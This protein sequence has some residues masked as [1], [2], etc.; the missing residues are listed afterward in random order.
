ML[1]YNYWK[2]IDIIVKYANVNYKYYA[3]TR[4]KTCGTKN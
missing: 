2:K 4:T 1:I 3:N